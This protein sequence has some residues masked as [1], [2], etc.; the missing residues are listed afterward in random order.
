MVVQADAATEGK[1]PLAFE[2][3]LSPPRW[4]RLLVIVFAGVAAVGIA[5]ASR[6][7]FLRWG[8][9]PGGLL[10][11]VGAGLLLHGAW[12]WRRTSALRFTL[13]V[14]ANGEARLHDERCGQC[15][16]V[17]VC[18]WL[19]AERFVALTLATDDGEG[20]EGGRL[21]LLSGPA[22]A[23][24]D[25]WRR[26]RAWLAWGRRGGMATGSERSRARAAS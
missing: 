4:L 7:A 11:L 25:D 12:A 1:G 13:V 2:H 19:L 10:G 3:R 9:L 16:P 22:T 20:G 21:R 5:L 8:A 23:D 26:L 15:R 18:T 6:D 17:R 14:D 24:A